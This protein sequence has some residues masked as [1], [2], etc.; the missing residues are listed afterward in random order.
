MV[1][2]DMNEDVQEA[3]KIIRESKR[4]I[5]KGTH[6]SFFFTPQWD[7]ARNGASVRCN[8]C[9]YV[10]GRIPY[11]VTYTVNMMRGDT[12]YRLRVQKWP[13]RDGGMGRRSR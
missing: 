3:M 11:Q 4:I 1:K 9:Q 6:N 12:E 10:L 13:R 5:Q 2:S 7:F 8:C